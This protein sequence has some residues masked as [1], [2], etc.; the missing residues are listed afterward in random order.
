MTYQW[1]GFWD[2]WVDD[3]NVL[4]LIVILQNNEYAKTFELFDL[5]R[6]ILWYVNS[7]TIKLV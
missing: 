6:Q 5:N 2:E 1:C 7:I 3:E 4:K